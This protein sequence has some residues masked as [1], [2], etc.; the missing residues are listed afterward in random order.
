MGRIHEFGSDRS[1]TR[2]L[3]NRGLT[4]FEIRVIRPL[5]FDSVFHT[6]MQAAATLHH[7][8]GVDVMTKFSF[9]ESRSRCR[10]LPNWFRYLRNGGS[11]RDCVILNQ[12]A[13]RSYVA[14]RMNT[15]EA[16]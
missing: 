10:A 3:K 14:F 16:S 9:F 5:H 1:N 11:P 12:F 15:F 6:I 7:V 13:F 4:S 2:Y 8:D